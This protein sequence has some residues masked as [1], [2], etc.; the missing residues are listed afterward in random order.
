MISTVTQPSFTILAVFAHPD[1]EI[2]VGSTLACYSDAGIC[3]VLACASRGEAATIYCEDCA[4]HETLGEVRTRELECACQHLGISELRWLDWPDGG[5]KDLPRDEA[6]R[7]AV[8]LIREIRP[9]VILTHPENGLYPHPDHLA[10]WEIVRAAF[11]AAA[12]PEAY[13]DT[14]APWSASRLF[15][16]ALPQSFFERAPGLTQ[17]RVELNGQQL[18]FIGTPDDQL[19]VVMHVEPWVA[20]RM[21]AWDCHR[22]QHNPQGFTSTMPDDLRQEMAA[23]ESYVLAA[24]RAPLPEG[25]NDDLLVG[26]DVAQANSLQEEVHEPASKQASPE[27]VA[28]LRDEL[29]AHCALAELCQTYQSNLSEAKYAGL[30]KKLVDGEQQILYLLA[31]SL[32]QVDEPPGDIEPAPRILTAGKRL[33]KI[34]ERLR[35]LESV[36]SG[37]ASRLQADAPTL[38][39]HGQPLLWR[40]LTTLLDTQQELLV[41]ANLR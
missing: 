40:E 35:F 9:Q 14:G 20:R 11:T 10:V 18:P 23:N 17:F 41:R 3:T 13:P 26:L 38:L 7:Q 2:G 32:R 6:V 22:S 19:D 12:D 39:M 1:D 21:A 8:Q 27:W 36:F 34:E 28:F 16:R 25:I 31:R 37:A 30:L 5:I 33:T 24:A 4:T 29:A 15:T